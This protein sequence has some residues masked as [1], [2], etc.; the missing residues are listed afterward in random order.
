MNPD[1]ENTPSSEESVRAEICR[2][3]HLVEIKN[4]Q[5]IGLQLRSKALERLY[6]KSEAERTGQPLQQ[7]KD[8]IC[9]E[10]R[11]CARQYLEAREDLNPETAAQLREYFEEFV[12]GL[13][14]LYEVDKSQ[15]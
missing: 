12:Q 13:E 9:A 5:L 7:M 10:V 4:A 15:S 3:G 11:D 6:A 1:S 14:D 2:L 8:T